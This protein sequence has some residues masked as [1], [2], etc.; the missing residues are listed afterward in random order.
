MSKPE[1]SVPNAELVLLFTKI[2][3]T[4]TKAEEA[5]KSPKISAILREIIE[6]NPDVASGVEEKK[7]TLLSSLSIALSKSTG[8]DPDRRDYAVKAIQIGRAHV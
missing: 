1:L 4:K 6:A 7:A 8:I 2:G 3:L 5:I